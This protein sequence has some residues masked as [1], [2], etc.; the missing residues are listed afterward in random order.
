M[1]V[2]QTTFQSESTSFAR[3]DLAKSNVYARAFSVVG[4]LLNDQK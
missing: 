1:K 3:A 4:S 2:G